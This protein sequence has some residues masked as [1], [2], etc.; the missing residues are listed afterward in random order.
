MFWKDE[1]VRGDRNQICQRLWVSEGLIPACKVK[2]AG[3]HEKKRRDSSGVVGE[4]KWGVIV[5]S[6]K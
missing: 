5:K 3:S 6:K 4:K 1:W 2:N